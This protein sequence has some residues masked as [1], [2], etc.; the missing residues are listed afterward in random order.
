[1]AKHDDKKSQQGSMTMREAGHLGGKEVQHQRDLRDSTD[2][3]GL[4]NA[5]Q[6]DGERAPA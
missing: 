2:E 3:E 5:E 6:G 1:M 4:T